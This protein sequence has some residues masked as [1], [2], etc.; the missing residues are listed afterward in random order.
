MQTTH[1]EGTALIRVLL[2]DD[3][4]VIR[5]GLTAIIQGQPDMCVVGEASDGETAIRQYDRLRP[6]A[7]VMDLKLPGMPGQ[8][9]V[10]ALRSRWPES[11]ILIFTTLIG[12]EHVYQAIQAGA[13]GYITK[14]ADSAELTAAIRRTA[15]GQR[16]LP[17]TVAAL[18]ERRL[19]S[20]PLTARE[21][22]ILRLVASGHSNR[23]AGD[24]LS[25]AENTVKGY[26]KSIVA[27]LD[28]PDR[29]AAAMIAVQRGLIEP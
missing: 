12:D 19:T 13:L 14:D 24:R 28:A 22:E 9:A 8:R 23:E 5:A 7:V 27:K 25:L 2:V 4:H 18:L 16:T 20:D 1:F 26:L 17:A 11:R 29:T 6:G 3:H 21:L 10:A 15:A